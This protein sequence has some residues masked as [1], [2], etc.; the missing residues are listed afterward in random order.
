MKDET[1]A[2]QGLDIS[3]ERPQT[4]SVGTVIDNPSQI[5]EEKLYT[6]FLFRVVIGKS[7]VKRSKNQSKDGQQSIQYLPNGY[8]SVY[9]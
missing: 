5:Q 6:Y 1:L 4:F 7:Y 3:P 8:D 2:R 9:L